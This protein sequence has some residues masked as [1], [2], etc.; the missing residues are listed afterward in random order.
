MKGAND[1]LWDRNLETDEVYYSPRWREMLGYEEGELENNP[2]TW[3]KLIHPDERAI[4]LEK[5]GQYIHGVIDSY[6]VEFRMHHK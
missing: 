6:E 4:V 5:M 2:Q 3:G 1:G